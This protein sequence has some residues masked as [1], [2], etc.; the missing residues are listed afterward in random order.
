VKK[1]VIAAG[2]FI[3]L[4]FMCYV[5]ASNAQTQQQANYPQAAPAQPAPPRTRIAL[6]NLTYVIKKYEKYVSFQN[7]IKGLVEPFTKKETEL[8]QALENLRTEASKM[9]Q[10][11]STQKEEL[12]RRYKDIQRRQEDLKT[13][14][15][16]TL[17]KR[18]DEAMRIIFM[19]VCDAAQRYASSH[20]IELVLHYNDTF[21][22]TEFL[23]AQNIA[24]KLNSGALM[25]LVF[26]EQ[27]L[28]IS[29][30]ILN[31]L[32]YAMRSAAT[33]A[34]GSGA[35]PAPGGGR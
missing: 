6:I 2:G 25:P 35:Q 24:R 9:T 12:E 30:A 1:T 27:R 29:D 3:V 20:D 26:M 15:S 17:N 7:E 28:D 13:E 31:Q 8:R 11:T 23:S 10:P 14:A 32:N 34:G 18:S 21:D 22:R 33:A 5:G 4:G 19:D 16:L